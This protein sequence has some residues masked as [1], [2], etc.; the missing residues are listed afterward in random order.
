[1]RA[2]HIDA[3]FEYCLGISHLYYTQL[4]PSGPFVGEPRDGVPLEEDLALRALVPQWKPKRGRKRVEDRDGEEDKTAKRPQLDTSM[5]SLHQGSFQSHSVTFPQSAIPFS[6]FPDDMESHDPWMTATP[7]YP[8]GNPQDQGNQDMRW[9]LPDR[10]ASPANFPQSAIIPR[11]HL[12]ADVLMSAEPR[13][14]VTPSNGEKSRARRRHGPAVS[15]AWPNGNGLS[16]GKGRG[17]P[18]NKGS[19]SGSFST[20]QLNTNRDSSQATNPDTQSSPIVLGAN[21]TQPFQTPSYNQSPTPVTHGRPSKLHLLVPQTSGSPVRLATPPMLTV[22]GINESVVL[23]AEGDEAR[24]RSTNTTETPSKPRT[25]S[26]GVQNNTGIP[27]NPSIDDIVRAL[28]TE[29]LRA[30]VVGRPSAIHPDEATALASAMVINISSIYS[31]FQLGTP[32]SILAFHLGIGHHFGFSG[33]QPGS[34]IMKVERRASSDGMHAAISDE[35]LSGSQYTI[36]YEHKSSNQ[37]SM[38]ITLPNINANIGGANI[39][40]HSNA[41]MASSHSTSQNDQPVNVDLDSD[42]FA[43]PAT[44]VTWKQ[45]YMRLRAQMQKRDQSLSQYRRKIIDSVMADI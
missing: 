36:S 10:D 18:P 24:P 21:P 1:M 7:S 12:P 29:L 5:G 34:L 43:E 19:S 30:K 20:F 37:L 33:T 17:R 35:G 39:S 41:V 27:P 32:S 9:R 2:M 44:E 38:R 6:A 25:S 14:A 8:N 4:P 13:S 22:N 40:A 26:S 16:A 23:R 42:E 3:F 28:S 45:R 31:Q 15:S 11:S